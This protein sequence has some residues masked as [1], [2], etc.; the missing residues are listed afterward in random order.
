MSL[1]SQTMQ[2]VNASTKESTPKL[3]SVNLTI[4]GRRRP[5][6]PGPLGVAT[7]VIALGVVVMRAQRIVWV[8]G[9]IASVRRARSSKARLPPRVGA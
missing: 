3:W 2:R 4:R 7:L 1:Q 8:E 6:L 5:K 9:G